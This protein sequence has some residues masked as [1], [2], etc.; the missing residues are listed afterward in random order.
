MKRLVFI[1]MLALV[2][3]TVAQVPNVVYQQDFENYTQGD[4]IMVDNDHLTPHLNGYETWKVE[5]GYAVSTSYYDNGNKTAD[6]WM[7]TPVIHLGNH[8]RLIWQ[9]MTPDSQYRDGYQI[10]VSTDTAHPENL[11]SYQVVFEI[12]HENTGWTYRY[13][14]LSNYANQDIRIAWRNN[15]T[16]EYL[17]Y[18]DNIFVYDAVAYDLWLL[19]ANINNFI[20]NNTSSQFQYQ[21][22]NIGYMPISGFVLEY[23]FQGVTENISA[24]DRKDTVLNAGALVTFSSSS[25]ELHENGIHTLKVNTKLVDT[26]DFYNNNDSLEK[27]L[28][29]WSHSVKTLVLI[30]HFTNASCSP[31][32]RYNPYLNQLVEN[33]KSK[34]AHIA[35][36]VWWP[37]TDPMYSHN[38][39]PVK[40]RV[41]YY[42][43]NGVPTAIVEGNYFTGSPNEV[44]Q[45]MI[46]DQFSDSGLVQINLWHERKNDSVYFHLRLIP[47]ADFVKPMR[48]F[49]VW[50]EDK[51]YS[52]PPGS[53]GEKEFLD[54][55]RQM[56]PDAGGYQL[57]SLREGDTVELDLKCAYDSEVNTNNSKIIAFVQD[58]DTKDIYAVFKKPFTVYTSTSEPQQPV[59]S[60]YPIPTHDELKAS[61]DKSV[62]NA[63]V[64]IIDSQGRVVLVKNFSGSALRVDVSNMNP[65]I[66]ILRILDGSRVYSH[67][68]VKQ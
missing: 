54:V 47:F 53:N 12:A 58:Y 48:L 42:G 30:E 4:M 25:F 5:N 39:E 20:K 31:C 41:K 24:S 60:L 1:L 2:N 59:I 7:I 37:G 28:S 33:N 22:F 35:Y 32:A 14:D 49:V 55:M 16:D 8:P 11:S 56:I 9:A 36:H 21:V 26:N 52:S 66:Y 38:P 43:V 62:Q 17:L 64:E 51:K 40:K 15:S 10:L 27:R 19:S 63:K 6:D 57:D 67:K 46:D 50:V 61:L 3:L 13:V 45:Q 18:V 23:T 68:F 34:V 44:T 65:G 29:V